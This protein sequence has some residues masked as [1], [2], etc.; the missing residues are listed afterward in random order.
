MPEQLADG[1]WAADMPLRF[2][3]LEFG[4]RMTLVRLSNGGLLMHSPIAIDPSMK[5]DIDALGPVTHILA[6]NIYHH[7]SMTPA[8]ELYPDAK[9][10]LAPGLSKKRPD[11]PAH[12]VLSGTPDEDWGGDIEPI[13]IGGYMLKETVFVHRPSGTLICSDL[14]EN[15]GTSDHWYTRMFL[16]VNGVHGKPGVSRALRMA[17][18]DKRATRKSIDAILEHPIEKIALAHG[19][20][21]HTNAREILREAY[22][23]IPA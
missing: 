19:N 17:Y 20:P 5:A 7:V 16:K 2:Y 15:F 9:V 13:P 18:R 8:I 14:V 3:G 4:A 6:P 23:W 12:A 11:L 21:I 1:V 10:H 22:S